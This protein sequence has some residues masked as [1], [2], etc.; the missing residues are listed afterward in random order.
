MTDIC[1][2][3]VVLGL[4]GEALKNINFMDKDI[5]N[6]LKDLLPAVKQV[7]SVYNVGYFN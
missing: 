2:K 7:Q 3:D 5:A 1:A 4:P 6:K